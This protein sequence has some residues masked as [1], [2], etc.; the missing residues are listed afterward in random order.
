MATSLPFMSLLAL[1][2][3]MCANADIFHVSV[4]NSKQ[5]VNHI[6]SFGFVGPGSSNITLVIKKLVVMDRYG[7][8]QIATTSPVG[9]SLEPKY[10]RAGT[11]PS[12]SRQNFVTS[13]HASNH[14]Y[15]R[16]I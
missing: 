7:E 12:I 13:I 1:L 3:L 8:A 9:F 16:T 11:P 14:A 15:Q 2:G 4:K 10:S 5:T 6:E